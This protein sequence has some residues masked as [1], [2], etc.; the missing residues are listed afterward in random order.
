MTFSLQATVKK[1]ALRSAGLLFASAL[2]FFISFCVLSYHEEAEAFRV[3]EP[4]DSIGSSYLWLVAVAVFAA[5]G[6]ASALIIYFSTAFA[7]RLT[8]QSQ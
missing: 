5:I 1:W 8:R 6:S 7:A 4:Y 3:G 2:T